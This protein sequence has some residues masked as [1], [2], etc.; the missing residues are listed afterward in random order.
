MTALVG[1][2][3]VE[4]LLLLQLHRVSE[5][6]EENTER[7]GHIADSKPVG[8]RK[9]META[10][11]S[12]IASSQ[13]KRS[14]GEIAPVEEERHAA[15]SRRAVNIEYFGVAEQL[16]HT[17]GSKLAESKANMEL[18][19]SDSPPEEHSTVAGVVAQGCFRWS[20]CQFDSLPF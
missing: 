20:C 16:D 11:E 12:H 6:E 5:A 18:E 14:D 9:K 8:K 3:E 4:G 17:V 19:R 7:A 15:D 10:E 1:T 13:L 2:E